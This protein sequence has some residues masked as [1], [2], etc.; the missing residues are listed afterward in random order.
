MTASKTISTWYIDP[1]AEDAMADGHAPIWR[2]LIGLIL[3]QDL[4]G[5]AVLDFGCNQ[6]GFLRHLHALRPFRQALGLDIATQSIDKANALKGTLP[7]QYQVGADLTGWDAQFDL[8]V[9]HEVIYLVPDIAG[10]ARD[11]WAALKP[12]GVYYAVTGC[13]TGNPLW[14][15][16]RALV[17]ERTN[18]VVQDRSV[19]D[20]ASAFQAAGFKVGARKLAFDGFVPYSPGGWMPDF[21]DAL[22]YYTET[23]IVFR[24]V[25]P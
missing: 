17:A 15:T 25:K 10:H 5:K 9:S 12:G 18:T 1:D 24:L 6:G 11:I 7:I 14:P 22:D 20:Y 13:H 19:T 16:W 3:E 8:A 21:A 4:S 2:H 23:K